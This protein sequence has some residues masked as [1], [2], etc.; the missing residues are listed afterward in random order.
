MPKVP[1]EITERRL[2]KML[3]TVPSKQVS[4]HLPK[5]EPNGNTS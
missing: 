1:L 4:T 3:S 5:R 2:S